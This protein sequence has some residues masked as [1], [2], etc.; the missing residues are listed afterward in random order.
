[1]IAGL[2][3]DPVDHTGVVFITNSASTAKNRKGKY[4]LTGNLMEILYRDVLGAPAYRG[5]P[6]AA[7][8]GSIPMPEDKG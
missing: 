1:M 2:Y 7:P 8:T 3:F 5:G 4:T 6:I